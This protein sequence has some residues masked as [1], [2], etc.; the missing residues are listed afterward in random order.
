MLVDVSPTSQTP[1]LLPIERR[2]ALLNEI[3]VKSPDEWK[4]F[5]ERVLR[6]ID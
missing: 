5:R 4:M 6:G 2:E 3:A 1:Y